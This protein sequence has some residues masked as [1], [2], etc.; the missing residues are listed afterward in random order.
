MAQAL[1][2]TNLIE[3]LELMAVVVFIYENGPMI[4]GKSVAIYIDNNCALSALVKGGAKSE[5]VAN[6]VRIFW[7]YVQKYDVNVWRG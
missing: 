7:F 5:V 1:R 3:G 6:M 2:S 4:S